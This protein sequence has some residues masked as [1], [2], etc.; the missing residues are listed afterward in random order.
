MLS[1]IGAGVAKTIINTNEATSGY[2]VITWPSDKY[3]HWPESVYFYFFL[4]FLKD[5]TYTIFS[6]MDLHPRLCV[7]EG[8]FYNHLPSLLLK[9]KRKCW[10]DSPLEELHNKLVFPY[11]VG[12]GD[13]QNNFHSYLFERMWFFRKIHDDKW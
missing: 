4:T 12:M 3:T 1:R 9:T 2:T 5:L 8:N 10:V 11:W 7:Y 13:L 6:T